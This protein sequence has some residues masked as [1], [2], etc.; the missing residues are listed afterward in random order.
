MGK[1]IPL[2]PWEFSKRM[3]DI[4]L[5]GL[6][7]LVLLVCSISPVKANAA[8]PPAAVSAYP[9]SSDTT[10]RAPAGVNAQTIGD[11]GVT[12]T[13]TSTAIAKITAGAGNAICEGFTTLAAQL[14]RA[15][16]DPNGPQS[17]QTVWVSSGSALAANGTVAIAEGGIGFYRWN[18]TTATGTGNCVITWASR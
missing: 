1:F 9:F 6:S 2:T 8:A 10:R 3:L 18:I 14:Q 11:L 12:S 15:S 17:A 13:G 5:I 16:I 7:L 4:I